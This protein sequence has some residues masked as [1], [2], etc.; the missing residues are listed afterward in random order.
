MVNFTSGDQFIYVIRE[1][2]NS[3][4]EYYKIGKTSGTV[5]DGLASDNIRQ[6]RANLQTGN[7]RE[8]QYQCTNGN[9]LNGH[10]WR[11]K[12]KQVFAAERAAYKAVAQDWNFKP[13]LREWVYSPRKNVLVVSL[14]TLLDL[15]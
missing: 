4:A 2:T 14:I 6:R 12:D 3:R 7:P 8:L 1:G 11:V 9:F 13:A 5:I 15:T 10:L